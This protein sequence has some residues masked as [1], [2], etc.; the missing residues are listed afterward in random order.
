MKL[1]S[2]KVLQYQ[3]KKT[4]I[5]YLGQAGFILKTM[6]GATVAIDLYLSNCCER[7]YGY[8]RLMP[9]LLEADE[10]EF[11]AILITHAH[12]DHFDV[13][14]IPGMMNN[15]KTLL[16]APKDVCEYASSLQI[17]K[18]K[19]ICVSEGESASIDNCVLHAVF[20]DHGPEMPNAVG[21]ILEVD[22]KRIFITGDTALRLD[23]IS[24]FL[25]YGPIDIMICPINGHFGNMSEWDA[26]QLC[27]KI[28]PQ[29]VIPCHYWNFAE[30]GGDPGVFA[31]HIKEQLPC[32]NYKVMAMGEMVEF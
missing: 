25:K 11:D 17:P 29:V 9:Y 12:E 15:E 1:L 2:Q 5:F 27:E 13:D 21:Y 14:S 16:F 22:E 31:M 30:H 28:K 6:S 8:K 3:N 20:C 10:L 18:E 23:K 32:Q 24:D 7:L 19:M 4:A 26:V